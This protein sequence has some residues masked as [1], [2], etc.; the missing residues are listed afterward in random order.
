MI[1][2][3]FLDENE[4]PKTW[5]RNFHNSLSNKRPRNGYIIDRDIELKKWGARRINRE[6]G[7]CIVFAD[8]Q[9]AMLFLMKF[10]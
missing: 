3:E 9:T 2:L 8:Q 6:S 7:P 1:E 4:L 10:S 5:W